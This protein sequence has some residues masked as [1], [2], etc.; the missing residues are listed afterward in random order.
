MDKDRKTDGEKAS[1]GNLPGTLPEALAEMAR[2]ALKPLERTLGPKDVISAGV[3]ARAYWEVFGGVIPGRP[4]DEYTRR[5][6]LTSE[7]MEREDQMSDEQFKREFPEG[8]STFAQYRE[9][10]FAYAQEIMDP[11]GLNWVRVDWTWL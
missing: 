5:W 7:T 10:A 4:V 9:A 11:R 1:G 8:K 3:R 6:V 2:E